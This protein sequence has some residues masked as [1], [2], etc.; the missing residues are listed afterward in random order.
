M[1]TAPNRETVNDTAKLIMHRL[2]ARELARDPSLV[3][4]ARVQLEKMGARYPH[5]SFMSDWDAMLRRPV[6]EII[7][8]LTGRGQEARRLRL[9]SPFVLADGIDFKDEALRRRIEQAAKRV[10]GRGIDAADI[11]RLSPVVD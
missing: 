1:G 2:V 4:R 10:A 5:R 9:S 11:D 6:A 3:H 8:V 7:A